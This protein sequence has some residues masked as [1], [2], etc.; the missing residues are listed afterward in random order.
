MNT[1]AM[2]RILKQFAYVSLACTLVLML[3]ALLGWHPM[4]TTLGGSMFA[5]ALMAVVSTA[6][7]VAS[8]LALQ[9]DPRGEKA[10][11]SSVVAYLLFIVMT[12]Y[13]LNYQPTP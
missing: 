4:H 11:P 10:L 8:R 3:A 13:W 9:H 6:I 5:L 2:A 7:L 1:L 12:V